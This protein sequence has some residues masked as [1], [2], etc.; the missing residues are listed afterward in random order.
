MHIRPC[1]AVVFERTGRA[2]LVRKASPQVG[3]LAD[4]VEAVEALA[5]DMK[6][7]GKYMR[8][9]ERSIDESLSRHIRS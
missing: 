3:D 6:R 8:A 7:V 1:D 5:R 9:A 2:V 4:M